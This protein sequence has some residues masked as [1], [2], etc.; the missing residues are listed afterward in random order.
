MDDGNGRDERQI[1]HGNNHKTDWRNCVL[2][3]CKAGRA[4]RSSVSITCRYPATANK[5]GPRNRADASLHGRAATGV[6]VK[7][8]RVLSRAA[9]S[10]R[11]PKYAKCPLLTRKLQ[12]S[13]TPAKRKNDNNDKEERI[14]IRKND[15]D[16]SSTVRI[17]ALPFMWNDLW[18]ASE[19][20]HVFE[21]SQIIRKSEYSENS[22]KYQNFS[23]SYQKGPPCFWMALWLGGCP[24]IIETSVKGSLKNDSSVNERPVQV[25]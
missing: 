5:L 16:V 10:Y 1:V 8:R 17:L 13:L 9:R 12:I 20:A 25:R 23:T 6:T 11:P 22:L 19:H 14:A 7:L 2:V 15:N 4:I 24:E 18:T 21:K 3:S